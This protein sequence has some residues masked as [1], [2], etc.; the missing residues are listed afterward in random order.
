VIH[1]LA[2]ASN[3]QSN[4]WPLIC[5]GGANDSF[6][7]GMQA[8][9]EFPQVEAARP[10]CKY[11]ARP[12]QV[13]RIPYFVE[14][15]VRTTIMGRPGVAY[16]DFPANIINGRVPES[17]VVQVS[18][19]PDPPR[20]FADPFAVKDAVSLLKNAER[21]LIIMGKGGQYG[22]AEEECR[23]FIANTNLPFLPTP[24]GKGLVP[25]DDVHSVAAAR[26]QALLQA[27]VILLV[28]ARLNWMLHFGMAPRFAKDVKIIQ[29]DIF[30]EE[31]HHNVRSAVALCGDVKSVMGQLNAE[32]GKSFLFADSKPWWQ[33]LRSIVAKNAAMT[34]K[35]S[36]DNALPMGYYRAF[37]EIQKHLPRDA[38][39]VA[40][41]SNTMDISRTCI[42]NYLPRSRIDA[43]TFGTMGVG[44]GFALASAVVFPERKTV[45]IQGDSAFG[46]SAME[47][48]TL[49]RYK[50]PVIIVI[51]NNNGITS[52]VTELPEDGDPLPFALS[53]T[54]RYEMMATAFG[55][56]GYDVSTPAELSQCF[57]ESLSSKVPV[58][59]NCH[60]DTA[61]QRKQQEFSWL[62]TDD[63]TKSKM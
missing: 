53:P 59:I 50:L 25:D 41:G 6:Q 18:R 24:M 43:G 46:F 34:G 58:I 3:N 17:K 27:D 45:V 14:Q 15:A 63:T 22:R 44:L 5:I 40:E 37:A 47:I 39:I 55:G 54:A 16:L 42:P 13:A 26:S 33:T 9:Q 1:V 12:D 11:A 30:M 61:A 4:N 23:A 32:F 38:M 56:K 48:E 28:G 36:S 60:I 21:P 62:T 51:I 29:I 19:C 57:K 7:D 10:Y 31:M 8:F 52:G 2:G 49:C 20:V 35:M